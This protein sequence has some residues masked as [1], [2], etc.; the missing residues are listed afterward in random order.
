[1]ERNIE[2]LAAINLFIT[3]MS[4]FFQPHAWAKF[5]IRLRELDEPGTFMNAF[6]HLGIGS[7]VVSFH[8][9]WTGIS[10]ILTLLGWGW[11]I[12]G[13]IYFVAPSV[14]MKSLERISLENAGKFRPAGVL[15]I[16]V[17][18]LLMYSLWSG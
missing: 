3:G 10:L 13:S 7:L 8:N 2:M 6:I 1:M 18:G 14:G 5:F 15:M 11:V 17:S 12:K 16:V 9:V 4:H